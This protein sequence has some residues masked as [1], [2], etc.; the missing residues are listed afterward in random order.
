MGPQVEKKVTDWESSMTFVIL[1][2]LNDN[3]K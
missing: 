1:D 2:G 3:G